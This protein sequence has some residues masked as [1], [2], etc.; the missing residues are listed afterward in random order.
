VPAWND[1]NIHH[2]HFTVYALSG[3][4]LNLSSAFDGAATIEAMKGK[5]L[6]QGE[7]LGL[8]TQN[9]AKGAEMPK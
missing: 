5:V 7:V 9:P 1:E 2:L 3:P 8:Y 6:A 4:P